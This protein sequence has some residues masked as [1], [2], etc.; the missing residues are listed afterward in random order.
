MRS[1]EPLPRL[2][3]FNTFSPWTRKS[4]LLPLKESY[5]A[6]TPYSS[7]P[8]ESGILSWYRW[9]ESPAIY[10]SLRPKGKPL[11]R[12]YETKTKYKEFLVWE[13]ISDLYRAS[14]QFGF[15]I[16][17]TKVGPPIS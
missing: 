3:L 8:T 4:N 15:P 10:L 2:C 6:E 11:T 12:I 17:E 7:H 16:D 1:T 5:G 13:V 14:N 9:K